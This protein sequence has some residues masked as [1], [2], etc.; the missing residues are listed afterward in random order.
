MVA[1]LSF[2]GVQYLRSGWK[3]KIVSL[4]SAAFILNT[5]VLTRSRAA[6]LALVVGGFAALISIPR[7]GF[8]SLLPVIIVAALG[9]GVLVDKTFLDR[10][11]TINYDEGQQDNSARDR[12][13]SWGAAF[14]MFLDHPLYGVGIG[15]FGAHMGNYLAGHAGRDPHNSY[16]KCAAELGLP[17][18]V[19]LAMLIVNAFA[20]LNRISRLSGG[21]NV[22]ADLAW[23][24][25]G[26]KIAL[27]MYL[28]E[29]IFGSFNY[30]EMFSWILILPAALERVAANSIVMKARASG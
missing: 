25:Y 18:V 8:K 10:M 17:G 29:S 30:I 27:A 14:R 20:I 24:S 19:L 5:V 3:G 1:L 28:I 4:V 12:V 22:N 11:G 16:V 6:F 21:V 23:Q 26:L 13:L 15:N 2:A 9:A 7:G